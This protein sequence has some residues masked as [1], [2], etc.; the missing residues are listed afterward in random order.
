MRRVIK[1]KR[2]L[3][4]VYSND[5]EGRRNDSEKENKRMPVLRVA[6]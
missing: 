1:A 3:M 5:C 6:P 2:L 4:I